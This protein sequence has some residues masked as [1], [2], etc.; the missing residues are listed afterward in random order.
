MRTKKTIGPRVFLAALVASTALLLV[1]VAPAFAAPVWEIKSLAGSTAG[2]VD[3]PGTPTVVEDQIEYLIKLRNA[4][5]KAL[6]EAPAGNSENCVPGA[7]PPAVP[8]NCYSVVGKFPP[9]ITPLGGSELPEGLPCVIDTG[10]NSI[11][12][13][14]NG[15]QPGVQQVPALS[16]AESLRLVS[17]T[18]DVDPSALGK[19]LTASFEV[20]GGGGGSDSVA[21]PTLITDAPPRFGVDAFDGLASANAAGALFTQAGGHPY[22]L[23]T[24]IEF[25]SAPDEN[26]MNGAVWPVEPV[27]DV[28]VDL[29]P[30]LLGNL[31]TVDR[32][33]V[34][35]LTKERG[36]IAKTGCAPTAQVGT[37]NVIFKSTD[38]IVYGPLPVFSMVPP[39]GAAV[40]FGF[41]AAGTPV[42][43]DA[44]VREGDYGI[45]IVARK[46]SEGLPVVG[47]ELTL[48]GVPS[49]A[50]HTPERGCPGFEPPWTFGD[51]C[52]SG[53]PEVPLLR[54][55]TACTEAGEGLE[56]KLAVGS[57]DNPASFTEDDSPDLSDPAWDEAAYRSHEAPGFS[58]PEE[59]QGVRK[60]G[61]ERGVEGCD[62]VPLKGTLEAQPTSIDTETSS[63]LD[64]HVEIPNQGLTNK[65]GIASSDIKKVKVTL[66][67]GVTINPSQ[68]E[69]LGVCT[70]SQYESTELSFFP[71]PGKGCPDDSKIG[72]VEVVTPLLDEHLFGDVFIA[73]QDDP[74]T[75]AKGAEN[76]FDSLLALYV[77]IE[78]PE[79]G[80]L[81]R[82][83]G[84]VETD[85]RTGRIVTTFDDLP[86][87][88]FS[89][90]DFKFREGAR[91]PLVTPPT[92]GTYETDAEFTGWS[93]VDPVTGQVDPDDV[94]HTTSSFEIARGIGGGSCPPQGVRPFKPGF[95]AGSLNNNAGSFSPFYL[96][97]TRLDGE[98][99]LTKFNS[100]LPPGVVAKI[101]GVE[102]CSETQIAAAHVTGRTGKQELASPSCPAGSQIGRSLA[103]AGVGSVQTYVP[104]KIY[105]AGP[106]NGAPLSVVAITPAVAGPFD[107]GVVV[108]RQALTLD[109]VTGVVHVDGDRSDPIPHILKGIPL[110]L[111]DLR[112]YVDRGDFTINPTS[113]D[114][115][116]VKATLFGSFLDVFS[117]A[118]DKPVDLASRY[119]AANCSR[120]G[121]KPALKLNLKGGTKR[122][123]HPALRAVLRP[124]PGDANLA[125]TVVKLPRSA[126][127]DQAHIR[128]ICTRVQF[129]ADACP[130]GAIY[131]KV[132]AFSPLLDEPLKGPAYLRSSNN[133]LP[134]LVFDLK[135]VVDI[136]TSA[137]I[138]SVRGGIR[139]TFPFVPDAPISRVVVEMQGGKK[140]LIQN[141][142]NLCRNTNRAEV[143]LDGHNGK[144]RDFN[145][146]LRPDCKRGR[147]A[148]R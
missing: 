74:S 9:G 60:W 3:D 143:Q 89:S 101:A 73:Q 127:L 47:S 1:L 52:T 134:D 41:Y 102:K 78:S 111:R 84:K 38:N 63:G 34:A 62:S 80:I 100:V 72:T 130:K 77:V 104:G 96:R 20:L 145:P 92:C 14:V 99:D 42:Y 29:P 2:S 48:W 97:L 68:A 50:I 61:A 138:D 107:V 65:S 15:D 109:P 85:E 137:R 33:T 113:C 7:L 120:L 115:S 110:K 116:E 45:S 71:T 40:R 11:A 55:P 43:L 5:D 53:A 141:S 105:L 81:V 51:T 108:V 19:T 39:T 27:K 35:Q 23:T 106:Y 93:S 82:L 21:D 128:T 126:F 56:W 31:T 91:A 132:T 76:P 25:K 112:V 36:P 18:A 67:Q 26:P 146:V 98:Q 139:A 4:G 6:P 16:S 59:E 75:P 24:Q 114:P 144:V 125:G 94:L 66:P 117:A 142:R 87:Q 118:D 123:G 124:R 86:Q 133:K 88:P 12:C 103:G 58:L 140:G 64:V 13:S 30:G 37:T 70:P 69:G 119:Q 22:G 46:I 54:L 10:A 135:G 8:S 32:C 148:K 79:R 122:G 49:A 95:T 121:F 44:F 17:F 28:V 147:K 136:E 131:G 83:P 57:W 90:F 129:A